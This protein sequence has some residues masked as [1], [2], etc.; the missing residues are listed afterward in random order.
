[1]LYR[2]AVPSRTRREAAGLQLPSA[3]SLASFPVTAQLARPFVDMVLTFCE[4]RRGKL[5]FRLVCCELC[6][7]TSRECGICDAKESFQD[8]LLD[9]SANL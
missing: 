1:M 8:A 4:A 5:A 2:A 3:A 9:T 6:R 7:G